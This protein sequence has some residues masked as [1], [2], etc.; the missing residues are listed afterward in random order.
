MPKIS[1]LKNYDLLK[2]ALV[3]MT[4]A[5]VG[6]LTINDYGVTWDEHTEVEMVQKNLDYIL[7]GR[8]IGPQSRHYGFIFNAIAE[9]LFQI[10]IL[11]TN[12]LNLISI[13]E[14]PEVKGLYERLQLK[15]ILT[16]LFS[17]ITY[18]SVAG[19]VATLTRL[20]YA[21]IA[22][23][24]LALFPQF[25]G[26]SFFNPK[27]IPF[28]A[29]FTLATCLGAYVVAI[30]TTLDPAQF[31]ESKKDIT[32]YSIVYGI[33][34]GLVTGIRIGGFFLLFFVLFTHFL[35]IYPNY[36][37]KSLKI[38]YYYRH[39]YGLMVL[40]WALTTLL[41]YPSSWYNSLT[42]IGWFFQ[43]I[44]LMSKYT[45]WDNL[46]LFDGNYI[47]GKSLP[48]YYLPKMLYLTIPFIFQIFFIIGIGLF[49]SK[50]KTLNN[51]QKA[52]GIL[53]LFQVFFLP[54]LAILGN[55]TMYD[56]IR[57]FLFIIP[58]IAAI[59]STS[60]IWIYE[61]IT[62]N[63]WKI[64]SVTLFI[65]LLSPIVIDMI[66]LHPYQ[67]L[68]YNRIS[69]GLQQ[70]NKRYETDYWG[71]SIREAM[72]WL[73]SHAQ[74]KAKIVVTGPLFA[75]E[76]FADSD[77]QFN[78]IH[79]DDFSEGV[80]PNPD[81]YLGLHRS[82]YADTFPECTIIYQVKRQNVPL[83]TIKKCPSS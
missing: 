27:D 74:P 68:Y 36:K 35:L 56:G 83:T 5:I 18:G 3:I 62:R 37:I 46:V 15:H 65:I 21:W 78:I 11:I 45:V 48:W 50:Y 32:R 81:Y 39:F 8:Q 54:S 31:E 44:G 61:K 22:P 76:I 33:L 19:I 66:Q 38:L 40:Y 42:P 73:N 72:E 13:P 79:L 26:H 58:G 82:G 55:S 67:Y 30:Y 9:L 17:L 60:I 12:Q 4:L 57:H 69:G 47:P 59:A 1:Q 70:A 6:L 28:A 64:F 23:I 41:V 71:L 75:S 49:I 43:G 14:I 10:K 24:I 52:C 25:W 51:L 63:F 53:V 34:V 20:K 16:F 7:E 2:I 29:L 80:E 77:R